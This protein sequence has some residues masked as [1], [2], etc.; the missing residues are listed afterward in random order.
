MTCARGSA[1]GG[2]HVSPQASPTLLKSFH[3]IEVPSGRLANP[4]LSVP[5]IL[6]ERSVV[7]IVVPPIPFGADW[8]GGRRNVRRVVGRSVVV[9]VNAA[10]YVTTSTAGVEGKKYQ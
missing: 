5:G 1:R 8:R 3:R 6:R 10:T 4:L 2:W 7:E 9:R